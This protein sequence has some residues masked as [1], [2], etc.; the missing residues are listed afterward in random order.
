MVR[1]VDWVRHGGRG[2]TVLGAGVLLAA[3]GFGRTGDPVVVRD[4]EATLAADVGTTEPGTVTWWFEYG[5]TDTYGSTTPPDS[6]LVSDETAMVGVEEDVDGLQPATTYHYRVCVDDADGD[7]GCGDD[8][9]FTTEALRDRVAGTGTVISIPSLGYSYA[10]SV[11]ASQ[12]ADGTG[13]EGTGA[14]LPGSA[15]FRLVDEGPVTCLEVVGNR[16]AIGLLADHT[17]V[18][19]GIVPR[20][21]FIEDNGPTGDRLS[22][23][24][25][26]APATE[27]PVP[28]DAD[29]VPGSLG[30]EP[31]GPEIES[32]DFVVTDAQGQ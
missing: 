23:G 14:A 9:T 25:I 4:I 13:L 10:A 6:A 31:I 18:G 32:G 28:T 27:C 19:A 22:F 16:A 2:A 1:G 30:G 17:D 12:A 15:Y 24:S 8:R 5:P 11:D 26:E 21:V 29:F 20:L 7:G 3:C